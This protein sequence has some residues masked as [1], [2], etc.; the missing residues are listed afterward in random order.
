[1]LTEP[2]AYDLTMDKNA[3]FI[4]LTGA[5]MAGKSTFLK[6]VGI[7]LCLAY[8]GAPVVATELRSLPFRLHT[9]M[10]ITD[11]ITDGFAGPVGAN[12]RYPDLLARRLAAAGARLAVQNEGI[13]G[14]RVLAEGL[15]PEFGPKLLDRLDLDAIDQSG[16]SIAILVEGTNDL[17]LPPM[18]T[19]DAVIAGLQTAVDQLHAAGF[20]VILGTQTPSQGGMAYGSPAAIAARNAINDW[21]RTGGAADGVVDFH[22]A[23][24]DPLDPDALRPEFDSGDHLHPNAAGYQAM[25]DAVELPLLAD[26]PCR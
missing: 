7:N 26:P 11:S 16:A 23:L 21:I 5:N 14:N 12:G 9:C 17:G 10:R 2:V 13:S 18:A 22:T 8:A 19:A 24:S 25:A 3:N 1:M 6:T 15:I 4:F 20:R